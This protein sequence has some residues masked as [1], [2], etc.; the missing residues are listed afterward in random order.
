MPPV[1]LINAFEVPL[2]REHEF[3][4]GWRATAE[5]MRNQ[6]GYISTRL[7]QSLDPKAQFHFVNVAEWDSPQAFQAASGR[8]EFQNLARQLAFATPHPSLYRALED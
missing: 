4:K 7:H 1:I 3:L 5:Y 6:P 2:E 8:P